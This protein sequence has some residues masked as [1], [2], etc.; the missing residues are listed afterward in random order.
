M[1]APKCGPLTK[2]ESSKTVQ[3]QAQHDTATCLIV[4]LAYRDYGKQF[5]FIAS[6]LPNKLISD[7]IE[8]YYADFKRDPDFKDIQK[9]LRQRE[10]RD[11]IR[12]GENGIVESC[13]HCGRKSSLRWRF[14]PSRQDWCDPCFLYNQK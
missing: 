13:D 5:A 1:L 6:V 4:F 3:G 9:M 14:G 10:T 2:K 8:Y 7:V 12:N 11:H